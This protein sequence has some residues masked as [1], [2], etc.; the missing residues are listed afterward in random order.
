MNLSSLWLTRQPI[1]WKSIPTT[2]LLQMTPIRYIAI[3]STALHLPNNRILP[4]SKVSQAWLGVGWTI[5]CQ[6]S[7]GRK[8]CARPE[9]F[10]SIS[11]LVFTYGGP[12]GVFDVKHLKGNG[13]FDID[14][15]RSGLWII[16]FQNKSSDGAANTGHANPYVRWTAGAYRK[17]KRGPDSEQ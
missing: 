8:C 1:H 3:H 5:I 4:Q 12:R 13:T 11:E 9:C 15:R 6:Q 10:T 2:H 14:G 16:P 17:R 7:W